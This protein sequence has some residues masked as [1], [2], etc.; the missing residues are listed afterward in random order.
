MGKNTM[1]HKAISQGIWDTTY[2]WRNLSHTQGHE[3]F[4]FSQENLIDKGQATGQDG[5]ICPCWYH[6][7]CE[8]AMSAQSAGREHLRPSKL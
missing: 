5:A 8:V 4:A 7:T 1:M 3:G 2:L 6:C